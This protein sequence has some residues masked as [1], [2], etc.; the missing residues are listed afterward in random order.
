PGEREEPEI[1][2]KPPVMTGHGDHS[3]D[4]T[5]A[6]GTAGF[7]AKADFMGDRRPDLAY[8]LT[9]WVTGGRTWRTS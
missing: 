2:E 8:K 6:D 9:S 1:T 7:C 4:R 5:P 3:R